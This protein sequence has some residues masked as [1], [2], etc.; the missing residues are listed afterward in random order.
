MFTIF[1][2]YFSFC[3]LLACAT[4]RHCP[5]TS[6]CSFVSFLFPFNSRLFFAFLLLCFLFHETHSPCSSCI[7]F[8][9]F[10]SSVFFSISFHFYSIFYCIA[11]LDRCSMTISLLE[12][13]TRSCIH[14]VNDF[15]LFHV[16]LCDRKILYNKNFMRKCFFFFSFTFLVFC[17]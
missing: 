6:I 4:P 10:V 14:V 17:V 15:A 3:P 11:G 8:F 2:F 1:F 7:H 16:F 13:R 12:I 5:Y 9:L